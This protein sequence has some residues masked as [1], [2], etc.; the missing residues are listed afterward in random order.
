MSPPGPP[1]LPDA[2]PGLPLRTVPLPAGPA[3]GL[4]PLADGRVAVRTDEA[5]LALAPRSGE[6]TSIG[7]PA[8]SVAAGPFGLAWADADKTQVKRAV[9]GKAGQGRGGTDRPP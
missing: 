9:R 2:P 1:L 5:L 7:P 8:A 6:L 3:R 4:H